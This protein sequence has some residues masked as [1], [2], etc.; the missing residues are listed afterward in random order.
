L[1]AA[2]RSV[3]C[4]LGMV[5]KYQKRSG[6]NTPPR[7][8]SSLSPA[9]TNARKQTSANAGIWVGGRGCGGPGA[10]R[11]GCALSTGALRA[12]SLVFDRFYLPVLRVV[13]SK[14]TAAASTAA[15]AMYW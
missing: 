2:R 11:T 13:T 1:A 5:S 8:F 6:P 3:P 10:T 14:M 4:S 9:A 7:D 15:R 12:L